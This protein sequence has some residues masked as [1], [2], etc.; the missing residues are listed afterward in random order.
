[1]SDLA[2]TPEAPAPAPRPGRTVRPRLRLA[3][4]GVVVAAAIGFLLI[5]GLGSSLDYFKTVNEAM[6]S[7]SQIGTTTLRLEGTVVP[8]TVEQ[9]VDGASF[10]IA[11]GGQKVHVVNS[12]TPP[13]LF[14]AGTPVVV[15][16]H[17]EST[18]STT[19]LSDQIMVK[20]SADYIAQHP[21]RVTANDGTKH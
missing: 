12:G 17:F 19:F 4:V 7:K 15:V 16:G 1:V 21:D 3:L 2:T 5:K 10:D 18:A 9:R 6:A 20:H 14:K 8:G 13:Q 11:Q